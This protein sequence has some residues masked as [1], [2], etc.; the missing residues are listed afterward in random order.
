MNLTL[1][2]LFY[3]HCMSTIAL[4]LR[5]SSNILFQATLLKPVDMPVPVKKFEEAFGLS[6]KDALAS[7]SFYNALDAV[8]RLDRHDLFYSILFLMV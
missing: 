2:S 4:I 5:I 6:W 8:S 3:T 1:Y 7:G